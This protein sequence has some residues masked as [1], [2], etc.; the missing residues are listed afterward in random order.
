MS[1]PQSSLA[2]ALTF[3]NQ[4]LIDALYQAARSQNLGDWALLEK[5][6]LDVEELAADRDG[7]YSGAPIA[8]LP[9]LTEDDRTLISAALV[10]QLRRQPLRQG[11]VNAPAGLNVRVQPSADADL[12]ATL[13]D[14]TPLAVLQKLDDW[15]LV[16]TEEGTW[17]YVFGAFVSDAT[18]AKKPHRKPSSGGTPLGAQSG[19][20]AADDALLKR[21]LEP[22]PAQRI[23]PGPAEGQ[24]AQLLAKI[25]NANGG[26]LSELAERLQIDPAA[27]V[28]VLD[29]E[30]AGVGF[31]ADSR[32]IIRF[33]NHLFYHHWGKQNQTR[34]FDHFTFDQS[35]PWVNHTWRPSTAQPF[36]EF[37]GS[38]PAEW[39]VLGFARSLNEEAAKLSISMGAPQ[40]LGSNHRRIGYASVDAMFDAFSRSE[41][42]HILGLFDFIRADGAMVQ[43]LR[44]GDYI[45]FA[46]GY[47]GP[48]QAA[49]YGDLIGKRVMAFAKLRPAPT[50]VAATPRPVDQPVLDPIL[51][52]ALLIQPIPRSPEVYTQ[53]MNTTAATLSE[54]E[55]MPTPQAAANSGPSSLPLPQLPV[56]TDP[57]LK[58]IWIE[59]IEQG[60]ENNNIMFRRVLR[61]FMIPYYLTVTMYVL[62]FLLGIGL[63]AVAANLSI[64]SASGVANQA[65]ALVFAGLG[66]VTFLT[67]FIR[68]PMRSLEENLQFITWL[69]IIYNSYWT[70]LLYI[71]NNTSVQVDLADATQTAI[72]QIE[73][74]L[75]R[76]V[77][78][79]KQRP[80]AEQETTPNG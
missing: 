40:I 29:V 36:N 57:E 59:H 50:G 54:A 20:F 63:F 33:E 47:N 38:Q 31:G 13:P 72:D 32:M 62:L 9:N 26:L 28:A 74:M 48:G 75:E 52:A 11:T 2:P 34:F 45:G 43:A 15:L 19:Y 80:G 55:S 30:S 5:A 77:E 7:A 14:G 51:D 73:R 17:G 60:M 44:D 25:W 16:S 24:G 4:Q 78:I 68:Q 70:R 21:S 58:A 69:G 22:E 39:L 49:Y 3:T 66:V 1:E 56:A 67:F 79:A 27:A 71:Q 42:A 18:A 61:A 41:R 64:N 10:A 37:H 8:T 46:R 12:L 6:G 23:R 53:V 35:Q 65:P 76:N